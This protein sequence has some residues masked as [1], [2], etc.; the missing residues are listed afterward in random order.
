MAGSER[1]AAA[2]LFVGVTRPAIRW[3]VTYPALLLNL[4][5]TLEAFLVSRN[6][7]TLLACVPAHGICTLLCARDPRFFDLLRLWARTRLPARLGTHA[8]WGSSTCSPLSLRPRS[9]RHRR[10]GPDV[11]LPGQVGPC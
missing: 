3:G 1:P 11:R 2:E 10:H 9:A 7:L 6:L 8:Y 4:V 5:L